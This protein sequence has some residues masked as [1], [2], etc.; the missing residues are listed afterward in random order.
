MILSIF[1][2]FKLTFNQVRDQMDN[3]MEP[4]IMCTKFCEKDK[5]FNNRMILICSIPYAVY[6]ML[7]KVR[8]YELIKERF[9]I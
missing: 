5:F 7:Y 9:I 4:V 1:G 8:V 3:C 2:V 6:G